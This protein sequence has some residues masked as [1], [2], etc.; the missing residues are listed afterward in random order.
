MP[1]NSKNNR[2]A[3]NTIYLYLRMLFAVCVNLYTSRLVLEYLGVEDFGIYN[4]VGGVVWL[5]MFVNASMRGAT[6]RFISY[7][8]GI[9]DSQE[10]KATI[11]S[12]IQIH[13]VIAIFLLVV[14][15]TIGLWFVNTEL[16]IPE[17]SMQAAN[18][19]Y[20]FSI[21]SSM[22][23][24]IQVPFNA[25]ILSYE[26]MNIFALIEIANV[27]LRCIVV[28]SLVWFPSR[29]I[30]Y[31]ALLFVIAILVCLLYVLYCFFKIEDFGYSGRFHKNIVKEMSIFAA[32]DLFGNGTFAVRQQG[33]NILINRSF[34]VFY[35]AAGG[36]ATQAS[37][38]IATFMS[39][40]LSAFR[41]QIVKEYS[42]G[43]ISR[44]EK[45]M[46]SESE[47]LILLIG[48]IFAPLYIN[49]DFIMLLWLKNVPPYAV[50]F[51]RLL[52]IYNAVSV[53]NFVA[54]DGIQATG[55]IKNNSLALGTL[56]LLCLLIVYIFFLLGYDVSFAYY[57]LLI[58]ISCHTVVNVCMLNAMVKGLDMMRYLT[59]AI[60]PYIIVGVSFWAVSGLVETSFLGDKFIATFL[61]NCI[62]VLTC[63]SIFYPK[64]RKVGIAYLKNILIK[65][66]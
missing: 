61:L 45:L 8:L 37:S 21:L 15:E 27:S 13:F 32:C 22:V 63:S 46:C 55:N 2:L 23:T 26:K 4:I 50:V 59:R 11:S 34:G 47:I 52:L 5:M 20:Q 49:M 60:K 10:L 51:C 57:A 62:F 29:L 19:V 33:I 66:K 25:C 3:K 7:C 1:E 31:S 17:S 16:N 9:N 38:I 39:N 41:P 43:N 64:Y 36:V 42:V 53:V 40:V 44:M 24:I 35:N 30:G 65:I 18:W 14:G 58:C 56:N 12:A 28:F 6:S 48:L 54:S